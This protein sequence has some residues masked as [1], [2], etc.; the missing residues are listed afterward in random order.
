MANATEAA[1]AEQR[2]GSALE[3]ALMGTADLLET[4]KAELTQY[5]E[6]EDRARQKFSR[7]LSRGVSQNLTAALAAPV[8]GIAWAAAT[9]RSKRDEDDDSEDDAPAEREA[10]SPEEEQP[11][12]NRRRPRSAR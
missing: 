6:R 8:H 3:Q 1:Y 2:R 5:H 11:P 9:I 10:E 4:A 12:A 7:R